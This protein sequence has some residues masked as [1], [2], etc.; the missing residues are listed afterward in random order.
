MP[1][2]HVSDCGPGPL[3]E[4]FV[5]GGGGGGGGRGGGGLAKRKGKMR[6]ER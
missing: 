4:G 3:R 1:P 2:M 5:T 6:A